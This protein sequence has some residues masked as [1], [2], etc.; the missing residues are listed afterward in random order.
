VESGEP[1]PDSV[2]EQML[3]ARDFQSAMKLVR[4][5]EFAIFDLEAHMGEFAEIS[6]LRALLDDVRARVAV[7][8]VP[9]YNRFAHGFSHIFGGGYAAGY[10]S[11][12]WAEVLAADCWSAFEEAGV[13][14]VE[15][16][17]RYLQ[18]VLEQG[19]SREALDIFRDFRGREP[20]LEPFLRQHGVTTT[21][22]MDA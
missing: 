12:L 16:G 22:G 21:G 14:N 19:G 8:P 5:L 3:A 9:D 15:T 20:L 7:V 11:Y 13:F 1:L 6:D 17:R 18:T 4:Q 10:Y 2:R